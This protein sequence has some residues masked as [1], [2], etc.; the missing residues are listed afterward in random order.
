MLHFQ[1]YVFKVRVTIALSIVYLGFELHI[2]LHSY[3][4]KYGFIFIVCATGRSA[5]EM[6]EILKKRLHN[7]RSDE[8]KVAINEQNKITNIR[9]EKLLWEL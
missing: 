7:D 5:E 3:E 1:K 6:L 8:L 2:S 9:L 4:E